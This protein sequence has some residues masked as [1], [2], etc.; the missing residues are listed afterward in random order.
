MVLTRILYLLYT[1]SYLKMFER[2][3]LGV[4][5]MEIPS[6]HRNKRAV[7]SDMNKTDLPFV[8][9]QIDG[10][11]CIFLLVPRKV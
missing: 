11:S 9:L 4:D 8:D 5:F 6:S 7:K 10:F 2:V 3:Q 1:R